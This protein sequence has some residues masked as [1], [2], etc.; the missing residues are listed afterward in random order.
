VRRRSATATGGPLSDLRGA[1]RLAVE[2]TIGVAAVV[3][4]MQH[5][6]GAGPAILGR[7]LERPVRLLTGPIHGSI[8]AVAGT[9]GG[10]VDAALALLAPL[11]AALIGRRTRGPARDALVAVL[12]GV[13]GDH[14]AAQGNPLAIE[15]QLWRDGRPLA[16][17]LASLR[18][19]FPHAPRRLLV[20][21][22]GS[23]GTE[24]QWAR[25]GHDHGAALARDLG[26][27]PLYLRYNTGLHV[28]ANG[29]AL[30]ALVER[31]VGVWPTRVDELVLLAHS[32]GGL[33]SRSAC[34][35]AEVERHR[36]RRKLRALVFLGTPHHGAPLERAGNWVDVLLGV[37][38]YSAPLA[39][40]GKIRSAGVT[41]LRHGNVLDAHWAGR[42][43]FALHADDRVPLP[44]PNGVRCYAVAATT[45]ARGSAGKLRSDGLVAV[46]SALGRHARPELT[47]AFPSARR[48]IAYGRKHLDLLDA[49]E[50]YARLRA[51]LSEGNGGSA[52]ERPLT[53]VAAGAPR[54]RPAA[55][56]RSRSRGR[57]P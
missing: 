30:A 47:L 43:R 8:R 36:W 12:N 16:L 42:D 56:P 35:V 54:A 50:V 9:V 25:R 20:L 48:W 32:M 34:H 44:L 5:A 45:S 13:L 26:Y 3:E 2:A 27:A 37:S 52:G 21:V 53:G 18:R 10:G 29:R 23:C 33:V 46:D 24:R 6:I 15:M 22:H 51:W 57:A 4:A 49:P 40:L 19:A 11:V 38:H 7:P 14:L 28:S 1:S 31:L 41:D 39:Q 55:R 17:D